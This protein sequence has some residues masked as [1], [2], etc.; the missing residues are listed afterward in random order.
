MNI[1]IRKLM[2]ITSSQAL[3]I[4]SVEDFFFFDKRTI[5]KNRDSMI[6]IIKTIFMFIWANHFGL[7]SMYP[8]PKQLTVE[9][10]KSM[11]FTNILRA[12]PDTYAI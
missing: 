5:R 1:G 8:S 12:L 4:L 9:T 6:P 3:S 2:D 10:G 7:G 11:G